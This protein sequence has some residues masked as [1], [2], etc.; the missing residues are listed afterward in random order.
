MQYVVSDCVRLYVLLSF[1]CW[2]FLAQLMDTLQR[3]VA[4]K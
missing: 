1:K 4:H 3:L 2:V